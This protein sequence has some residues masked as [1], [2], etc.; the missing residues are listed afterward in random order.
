V[1]GAVL[2]AVSRGALR[3]WVLRLVTETGQHDL[4]DKVAS[5]IRDHL[6]KLLADKNA[7]GLVLLGLGVLK[8]VAAI[9]L[10]KRR[11][12]GYYIALAVV[13]LALPADVVHVVHE[14]SIGSG[15]LLA[16]NVVVLVLLLWFRR[17][18]VAHEEG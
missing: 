11:P 13:V 16:L 1:S 5:F 4:R 12:W 7:F 10:I 17:A 3:R 18:L 15:V 8:I 6:P 9:G 14:K 2:L